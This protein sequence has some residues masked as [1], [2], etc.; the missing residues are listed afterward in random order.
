MGG[1]LA[2]VVAGRMYAVEAAATGA[3]ALFVYGVISRALSL[4]AL[5]RVLEDAMSITGALL[6]LLIGATVFTLTV[7]AF[8][9]DR[10][11]ALWI[12]GLQ[13]PDFAVLLLGL[14]LIALCA[15]VLDAFEMIF[16]VV[17]LVA[18]ALLVR[19]PDATWV[20]VLILLVLQTSF[21]L[22]PVGYA[23][24]MVRSMTGVRVPSVAMGRALAPYLLVQILVLAAVLGMPQLV[25]RGPT[26]A[27]SQSAPLDDE[28]VRRLLEQ[29]TAPE[30]GEPPVK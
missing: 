4:P 7:R 15:F 1:L 18:P 10:A 24:L 5:R 2:A 14:G 25:W 21:V 29:Q 23:V 12:M 3:C 16:V 20:A 22:P 6:A 30:P 19:M 17:P 11:L 8:G 27:A 13:L 9:T 28:S 26:P